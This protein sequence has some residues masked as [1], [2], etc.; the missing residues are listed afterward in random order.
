MVLNSQMD[1]VSYGDMMGSDCSAF[2]ILTHQCRSQKT[3]LGNPLERQLHWNEWNP[4]WSLMICSL[5]RRLKL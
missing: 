4:F 1:H 3:F 5:Q 2:A